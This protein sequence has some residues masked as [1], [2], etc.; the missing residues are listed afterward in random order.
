MYHIMYSYCGSRNTPG[1][2]TA[3]FT[4]AACD[5][6]NYPGASFFLGTHKVMD[7][8]QLSNCVG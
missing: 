7:D 2:T 6:R 4:T 8:R 1:A 3:E 5:A